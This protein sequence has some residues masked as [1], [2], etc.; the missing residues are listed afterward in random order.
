MQGISPITDT[1]YHAIDCA[2]CHEPH[3]MTAPTSANGDT[4]LIREMASVTLADGTKVSLTGNDSQG[5]TSAAG[6]GLLCMQCH[7]ARV[8]A[9]TYVPTTAGSSHFG[10]HE[11]PQA[12]MLMGTNGYTYGESIPTSAH[13]FVVPNTCVTCHMQTVAS[14]DP[15]FEKA[16]LHTFMPSY[17]PTGGTKEDLV[18][19]CQTCHG[20]D[21]TTFDFPLFDYNGDGQ[22]QGVQTEVQS[23]LDQLSTMLPPNNSVKTALT[24]DSTWTKPQLEAAYNWTFVN[25]DGSKGIHNTAYAVGLLK[26]SIANLQ[27]GK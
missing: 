6:E 10:P 7:Q 8:A 26:A 15:A 22:I 9:N 3:G 25:N 27:A 19:A 1:T 23:M 5:Y 16:G 14:T 18:A 4:H 11:G 2:A 12:D 21:I 17:T 20:P 24:I 13:Q